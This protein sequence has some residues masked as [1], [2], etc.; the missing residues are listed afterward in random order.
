MYQ[1]LY[2]IK[3]STIYSYRPLLNTG[4]DQLLEIS[5][6]VE[7]SDY[8]FS[9]ILMQ[10]DFAY[11]SESISTGIIVNP[12]FYF[13]MYVT[14]ANNQQDYTYLYLYP[15]SSSWTEGTGTYDE[16]VDA[17][18]GVTW[19]YNKR[20]LTSLWNASGS[21]Y[22]SEYVITASMWETENVFQSTGIYKDSISDLNVDITDIVQLWL[23][24]SI[25]N[26]G[27]I[28]KRSDNEE[29]DIESY[30]SISFYS[31]DT[32]TIYSPRI[33]TMWDNSSFNTGLM[34]QID[35]N[36]AYVYTRNLKEKY[37]WKEKFRIYLG[38]RQQYPTSSFSVS[39][40]MQLDKYIPSSSYYSIVDSLTGDII[41]PFDDIGT[42]ISCDERGN[43]ISLTLDGFYPE[44]FYTIK[45]KIINNDIETI[46]TMPISFKVIK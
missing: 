13:Q 31:K 25:N 2:P 40:K 27:F 22:L 29:I 14:T 9:R 15:I 20:E 46:T 28:I 18:N 44:R 17:A 19:D 30:G 5:K 11:I 4:K 34:S 45:I 1:I 37:N 6:V 7:Q 38:V 42:K 41:I 33:V 12:K 21:D 23:S 39:D 3:D 36:N 10:F 32:H 8:N 43:Y 16:L 35:I 24:G 26:N